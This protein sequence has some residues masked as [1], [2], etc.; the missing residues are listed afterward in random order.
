MK[1]P[2]VN[3]LQPNSDITAVFLVLAKDVRQ[4]KTGEP[5]LSLTLGDRT[6]DIDGKMW[7]NV[8]D[9]LD[10]F[11]RD[12]FVKIR[13]RVQIFQNKPQFTIHRLAKVDEREVDLGDFF[14]VSA[15]DREEMWAELRGIVNSFTN[16]HLKA[17]LNLM[18]DDEEIGRRY[19]LAPAAKSIHHA[20]L[21]GLIEHVLSLLTL[22]EFT[23]K[24]YV[25]VDRDLL[26]TGV[27]LHDIG[28]IEELHYERSFGYTNSGQLLGHIVIAMRMID[29]KLRQL[30][31]FPPKLR[32]LVE[33]MVLSH[34]GELE[35]GSPKT[36]LFLEALLLHHLDNLDSKMESMRQHIK[37]DK[38]V[39]GVWT[40]WLNTMERPVLKKDAFLAEAE[41]EPVGTTPVAGK[42]GVSGSSAAS[43]K[44]KTV[45]ETASL[46][47]DKLKDA[48]R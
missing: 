8:E 19:K 18:L 26:L 45:P 41:P 5:Y 34:H 12:D 48:L 13:G 37:R 16:P 27:V 30:P 14:P 40:G 39:D 28:K 24:H 32:L 2:F 44:P 38:V 6:G 31:D 10:T 11:D 29:D 22:A 25:G 9:L 20:W 4:K 46:F 7:D 33:H 1:S 42:S 36:P 43:A 15:R 3:E 47:G 23:A 35:Y 17:L 21:G